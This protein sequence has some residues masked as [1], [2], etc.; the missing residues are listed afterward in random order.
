MKS[1]LRNKLKSNND[2]K[3]K[4]TKRM[5]VSASNSIFEASS[6]RPQTSK[7]SNNPL[8][9]ENNKQQSDENY[10]NDLE[11]RKTQEHEL[12]AF[13]DKIFGSILQSNLI[14]LF[15]ILMK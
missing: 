3:E 10:D 7:S 2:K 15:V 8:K 4:T 6:D 5:I 11:F 12:F 1:L 14:I 13:K 9:D